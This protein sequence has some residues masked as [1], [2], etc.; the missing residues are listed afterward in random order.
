MEKIK[1][2][3]KIEFVINWLGILPGLSSTDI[4]QKPF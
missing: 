2:L 3:T 1:N 4:R